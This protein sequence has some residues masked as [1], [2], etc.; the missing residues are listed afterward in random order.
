MI[1]K[2]IE[3]FLVVIPTRS[4][5]IKGSIPFYWLLL[6]FVLI[7]FYFHGKRLPVRHAFLDNDKVTNVSSGI[8]SLRIHFELQVIAMRIGT[9]YLPDSKL[10]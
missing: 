5:M 9:H 2:L 8:Y 3:D 7:G 1:V 4:I 6:M 10:I